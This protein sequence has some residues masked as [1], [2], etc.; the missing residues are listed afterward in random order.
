M[1]GSAIATAAIKQRFAD[2]PNR[3][4][5]GVSLI[6]GE[7]HRAEPDWQFVN[8]IPTIEMQLEDP[9]TSAVYGLW[10][11]MES[12]MSGLLHEVSCRQTLETV[13]GSGGAK[14]QRH[15]SHRRHPLSATP[16]T[17]SDRRGA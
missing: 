15:L 10:N 16:G 17:N 8:A 9:S 1:I 2:G 7:L 12:F 5:S 11:T 13:A 6:S 3:V 4:F 14:R